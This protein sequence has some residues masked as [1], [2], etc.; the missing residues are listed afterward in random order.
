MIFLVFPCNSSTGW[1]VCSTN[2]AKEISK[3][4]KIR[5]V[6]TEM[7]FSVAE[8]NLLELSFF[9]SL[10]YQNFEYLKN[11]KKYP[12]INA[13]EHDLFPYIDYFNGS[14]RIGICFSDREIPENLIKK[15][16]EFD[17]IV[18]GS[19]WCQKVLERHGLKSQVILQGIDPLFF[20]KER[21]EKQIFLDDFL[22]FSG[23]KFEYRKGQDATIKAYKVIQDKYPDVKLVCAWANFYTKDSGRSELEKAG[24]DLNRVIAIPGLTNS[25]MSQVYQNTDVGVF[26][27]RCEAGTNLVLMEYMACGKPAIATVGTG[28]SDIVNEKNGIV[29]ENSGVCHLV[30]KDNR[31]IADNW[32]EPNVDSIIDK[33]EWSYNNRNKLKPLAKKGAKLM[34]QYTWKH[35]AESILNLIPSSSE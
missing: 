22:I 35:M 26:P 3:K 16:Q 5:Y 33:L 9:K 7:D 23:G 6:T 20:N 12:I 4:E 11:Q 1:G 30:D 34:T 14:F 19:T 25:C 18:A 2:L 17:V 32:E 28:Q 27:S 21:S 13:L 31:L 8:R 24:V 10:H 29:L 15:A